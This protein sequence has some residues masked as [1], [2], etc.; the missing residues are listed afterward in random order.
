[1]ICALW[2]IVF[3]LLFYSIFLVLDFMAGMIPVYQ[4]IL[5]LTAIVMACLL[6]AEEIDEREKEKNDY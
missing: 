6:L 4:F 1:M 5:T 2:S 3:A